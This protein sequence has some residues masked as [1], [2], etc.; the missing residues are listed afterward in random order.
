MKIII[1]ILFLLLSHCA[2]SD[3]DFNPLTTVMRHLFE[4][5]LEN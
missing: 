5:N 1:I 2:H 4:V 3:I